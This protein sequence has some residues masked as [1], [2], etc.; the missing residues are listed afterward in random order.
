MQIIFGACLICEAILILGESI[1]SGALLTPLLLF[2]LAQWPFSLWVSTPR[3]LQACVCM[4][5][6]PASLCEH[7]YVG[8]RIV[9]QTICKCNVT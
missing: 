1:I 7:D 2:P 6:E 9:I 3:S 5:M 8:K 4:I